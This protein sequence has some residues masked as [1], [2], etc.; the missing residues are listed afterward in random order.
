MDIF[1]S[2]DLDSRINDRELAAV[3]EWL[4]SNKTLHSMRDHPW[5][6]VPI[7]GGGWGSKL[8]TQSRR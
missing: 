5:H 7:M 6:T 2:R 4:E 8:D 3:H 1:I